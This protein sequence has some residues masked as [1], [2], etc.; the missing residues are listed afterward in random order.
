MHWNHRVVNLKKDN[1]GEDWLCIQEV[2]Y[3]EKDEPCGYCDPCLG[4][5]DLGELMQQV[6]RF[7]DC[8]KYPILDAEKDFDNKFNEEEDGG[9]EYE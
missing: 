2:Y 6:K 1:Q 7:S 8:L 4:G 5:E 9:S 3:N